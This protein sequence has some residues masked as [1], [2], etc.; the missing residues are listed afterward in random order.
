MATFRTVMQNDVGSAG[1]S[2]GVM[3]CER[4]MRLL[5]KFLDEV[6][7]PSGARSYG[8]LHHPADE[9]TLKVSR[10]SFGGGSVFRGGRRGE[11]CTRCCAWP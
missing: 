4:V 10:V 3:A 11:G 7:R 5:V 8:L 1:G 6:D 9:T 2:Y